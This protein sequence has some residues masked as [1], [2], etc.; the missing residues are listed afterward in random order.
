[1]SGAQESIASTGRRRFLFISACAAALPAWGKS[2]PTLHSR[3]GVL[4]G[5]DAQ[6]QLYHSDTQLA[7]A[8]IDASFAEARRLESLF[9]LHRS[10]S[11]LSRLNRDGRLSNAHPELR[12]LIATAADVSRAT[13]GAF[14]ATVQPLWSLYADHFSSADADPAG[15]STEQIQHALARVDYRSVRI[16]E[17]TIELARP[18]MMLTLNG[19]A[20]GYV[21]DRVV[22]TLRSFGL[23]DVLVNMGEHRALGTQPGGA[24]WRI[25]LADPQRFWRTRGALA[26]GDRAVATSGG[27]GTPFDNNGLHHHLFDPR[28]G[29]SAKNYRSVTVLASSATIADGLS[30][31]ISSLPPQQARI[32]LQAFPDACALFVAGDGSQWSAG[33]NPPIPS[34]G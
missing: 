7:E 26:P 3:R 30:T 15:P 28:T 21:T 12:A 18:D 27:Y 22:E 10:D 4:L 34:R 9:S 17:R 6:V 13:S 16:H 23:Q 8:A 33:H 2:G 19:I 11:A 24:P 14:D 1:M 25:G 31:G 32:A 20:Q 29:R 5:A